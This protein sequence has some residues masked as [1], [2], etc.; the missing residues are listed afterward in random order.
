MFQRFSVLLLFFCCLLGA[1]EEYFVVFLVNA[2]SLDY[3][4]SLKFLKTV[5][6]HPRDGS[7]N[8]DVGHAWIYLKGDKILEGGHSG[9][10]GELQP[11]YMEGVLDNCALGANNP[12]SYLWCGQSDGFFQE[13]NGGHSPTFAAKVVLTKQQY[14]SIESFIRT[15]PFHDYSLTGHQ[16]CTFVREVAYLANLTIEDKVTLE[17]E[18]SLRLQGR[19]FQMWQDPKYRYLT[20]SSPDRLEVSLKQLVGEG[21]AEDALQWYRATHQK[22]LRCRLKQK[23]E[24]LVKYPERFWRCILL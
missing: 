10:L 24:Q 14:Q 18:P 19:A 12:V 7:K 2:R 15:Y 22:C 5:A 21:R 9:E 13:G 16:C 3:T 1:E 20:F 6:K 17:I 11:C 8:G 4:N 23:W